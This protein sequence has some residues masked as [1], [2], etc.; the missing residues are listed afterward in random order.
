M[1]FT[2]QVMKMILNSLLFYYIGV[3]ERK[4][5][6]RSEKPSKKKLIEG[7]II[8]EKKALG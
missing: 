2:L 5:E 4:N 6:E 7:E 8:Y 1:V 3:Y